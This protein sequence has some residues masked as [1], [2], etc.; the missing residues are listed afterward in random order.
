MDINEFQGLYH[1][2]FHL[3][4]NSG[5]NIVG[6]NHYVERENEAVI[7]AAELINS[8]NIKMSDGGGISALY[9]FRTNIKIR[10]S[11]KEYLCT[12][13][14]KHLI[15]KNDYYARIAES[16]SPKSWSEIMCR[17]CAAKVLI[18]LI[19]NFNPVGNG[20]WFNYPPD[21]SY[22]K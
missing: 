3:A 17:V 18:I 1:N 8:I 9:H 5:D 16:S 15:K 14:E 6:H 11:R 10:K 7:A 22:W 21:F 13:N 4:W 12:N 2:L 19:T 20:G